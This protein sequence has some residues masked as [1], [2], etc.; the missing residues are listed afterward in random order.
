MSIRSAISDK[1]LSIAIFAPN[2]QGQNYLGNLSAEVSSYEHS[3]NA[4]DGFA[5]AKFTFSC[6]SITANDWLQNGIGRH[7][8]V[9]GPSLQIIW[10]GYVNQLSINM[11]AVTFE[12]GPLTEIVNRVSAMYTPIF[13]TCPDP[14]II[15]DCDDTNGPITGATTETIIVEDSDS[16]DRYGIWEKVLSIG[17]CYQEDA[18]YIRD[19]YL[20]ENA[21]VGGGPSIALGSSGSDISV[22]VTCRG[23]IDWL[24][25]IYNNDDVELSVICSELIK[26]VLDADPNY[27]IS[28]NY[29]RILENLAIHSSY[30]DDN[31]TARAFIDEILTVGG[32]ND[33]R[34]TFG[35]FENRRAVYAPI[36]TSVEYI[37][38]K[39]GL[40]QQIETINGE[41]VE[42]WDVRPCKWV[43]I[44][45]FLAGIAFR[46][47]N[48][49]K[50]PRVFF[51]EEV[52]YTAPDS[53]T[54][55][56]GKVNR[57]S[58]Y[59]AK[60]GLGGV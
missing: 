28:A 7:I 18:E 51:A 27:I 14:A 16:Q 54:I 37:Y 4:T 12:R 31:K 40:T 2:V 1:G 36:P 10:E 43:G 29:S 47:D 53:V 9:Y 23:Y 22:S 11:G 57:L 35:I 13:D 30:T 38:H 60:L 21:H 26:T 44:P 45:D 59:M 5:E 52:S 42:P 6:N 55:N 41:L 46:T 58:Q 20:Y 8:V 33:D 24:N 49:R 34:W 3:I 50:D 48:I 19:L 32:G 56:G 25:Y 15:P 17:T 39:T